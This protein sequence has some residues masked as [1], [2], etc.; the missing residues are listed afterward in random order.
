MC[1]ENHKG[2]YVH[3]QILLVYTAIF[4]IWVKGRGTGREKGEACSLS[5]S[6]TWGSLSKGVP[7]HKAKSMSF[8]LG[9]GCVCLSSFGLKRLGG[10]WSRKK[11]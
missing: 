4:G 2:L 7:E 8:E 11:M 10:R 6:T 3:N 9:S 5:R 1:L